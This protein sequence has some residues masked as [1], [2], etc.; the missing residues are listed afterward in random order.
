M[1]PVPG[2][3]SL[4]AAELGSSKVCSPCPAAIVSVAVFHLA[5]SRVH[6]VVPGA[7]SRLLVTEGLD[8]T[9]SL[10]LC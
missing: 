9:T 3:P 4:M 5:I 1:C 8:P 10:F 6:N 2:V 7:E